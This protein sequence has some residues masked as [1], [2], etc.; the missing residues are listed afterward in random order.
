MR[1]V[2]R[3]AWWIELFGVVFDTRGFRVEII[4]TA[5]YNNPGCDVWCSRDLKIRK[6]CPVGVVVQKKHPNDRFAVRV[7][8]RARVRTGNREQRAVG[9]WGACAR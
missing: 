4:T 5:D 8:S 6:K 7:G 9:W 1:D 2:D 3:S